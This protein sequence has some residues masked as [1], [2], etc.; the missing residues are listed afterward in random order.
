MKINNLKI[1]GYGKIKDKEIDFKEKINI[2]QG[3]NE[4][5][6]ST[7][8]NFINNMLYGISKNKNG[9]PISDFDKYKPW[10]SEEF[11][12]KIK[13]TLD[14][15]ESYEIYRDFKKKNPIIY[16]KNLK[17]ISNEYAV[18]KTSGINFL[19]EQIGIDEDIFKNTVITYQDEIKMSKAGQNT[20]IQKISNLVSSGDENISFKK[21]LDKIN[22][23]QNEEVGTSRT[24]QKPINIVNN[25][26]DELSK[27]KRELENYKNLIEQTT[28][29]YSDLEETVKDETKKTDL[30][31]KYRN[32]LEKNK[33]DYAEIDVNKN[34]EQDYD[35]KIE[36]LEEK[37]DKEA[38]YRIK[39]EKKSFVRNYIFIFLFTIIAIIC[40]VLRLF[41]AIPIILGIIDIIIIV[42]TCI[43][44]KKFKNQKKNKL[45][46]LEELERKINQEIE[47]LNKNKKE[48]QADRIS[49][50]QEIKEKNKTQNQIL[51]QEFI[52]DLSEDFIENVFNMNYDEISVA[53][54]NKE[55]RI[56][57]LKLKL[58]T[59]ETEKQVM[60]NKLDDLAKVQENLSNALDEQKELNSLNNSYNIAKECMEIAY[61]KIRDS[62]SPEFTNELC[63]LISNI[64][65]GK[66]NKI[67]FSDT[68][69]LTVEIDDG[70]Y[71]SVE[72]L[73]IGTIDQ[74]Y[75]ALRISSL[76]TISKEKMPIIL[77]EA[78][79]Y[80]DD[81]RLKNILE[82]IH[83]N[84]KDNQIIIFTCSDREKNILD[85][86]KFQYNLI[87]LES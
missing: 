73:S 18:D 1:N 39:K 68:E 85:N 56:N 67:K 28:N 65:N 4:A 9:K 43:G 33:I 77:D 81:E 36:E 44:I 62:L 10:K 87:E 16:D 37:I 80:F 5:G 34:L 82:F 7:T 79:V 59:K 41:I 45:N 75:L 66:Y 2:V 38:K 47:I 15:G 52:D 58:H 46:E 64:S 27:K 35:A 63:N 3:K 32:N 25:K 19:N 74:M 26:I 24:T 57:E 42:A 83:K 53:I 71:I 14:N 55:E 29:D 72:N 61:E 70:R 54:E 17:D 49:K 40:A 86:L 8:L 31:K 50:E 13:Y 11:S 23:L 20:V 22:K 12:G 76:K 60:N 51:K 78:F 30:L 21:T 84:Y 48:R 69:G 6:K